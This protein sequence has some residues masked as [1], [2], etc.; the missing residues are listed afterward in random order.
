MNRLL[1]PAA[2]LAALLH[3]AASAQTAEVLYQ[4]KPPPGE[5]G[6][7]RRARDMNGDGVPDFM[8]GNSLARTNGMTVGSATIRSGLDGRV[9]LH[10]FGR[11]DGGQF[12]ANMLSLSDVDGDG[13]PDFGVVSTPNPFGSGG[14]LEVFSG[15]DAS[16]I[17]SVDGGGPLLPFLGTTQLM[18]DMNGD[19]F[20]DLIYGYLLDDRNGPESGRAMI[21]SGRDGSVLFDRSGTPESTF[22]DSFAGVGDVDGD[23]HGD[24]LVGAPYF[25]GPLVG[26]VFLFSGAS[27]RIIRKFQGDV[28][29][30]GFGTVVG[31]AGDVDADGFGDFF[32]GIPF[33]STNG[34]QNGL[35]RVLSGRDSSLLLQVEG[36]AGDRL[37]YRMGFE[38][39]LDGDGSADVLAGGDH[40]K[41]T[42]IY[43]G[44]SGEVLYEYTDISD[45]SHGR[46]KPWDID[47]DGFPDLA[48]RGRSMMILLG[49]P[50]LRLAGPDPGLAGQVNSLTVTGAAPGARVTFVAGLNTWVSRIPCFTGTR[51]LKIP[52][53]HLGI[54]VDRTADATGSVQFSFS[55]PPTM[56]GRTLRFLAVEF[57]TCRESRL[58]TRFFP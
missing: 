43:S 38:G 14:T 31:Y 21:L 12:G 44:K 8:I 15:R 28:P 56:S 10:L 24:F 13:T 27:G 53:G 26:R 33:A 23:G 11:K 54:D 42:R 50:P 58:I 45:A 2:I 30:N 18:G 5:T 57:A 55:V 4:L 25:F 35:F 29:K 3:G 6:I 40:F 41:P 7:I 36:E 34:I 47:R 1:L 19:G 9:L 20:D 37:G 39:D 52:I 46:R 16:L 51:Q 49:G 32:F 17:F 48:V 22:G